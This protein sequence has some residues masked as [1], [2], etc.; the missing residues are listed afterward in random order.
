M[1]KKIIRALFVIAAI[2]TIYEYIMICGMF[3]APLTFLIMSVIGIINVILSLIEKQYS[4]ALLYLLAT[5]GL[6]MGY[7]KVLF[8][9]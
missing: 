5:I 1:Y 7:A 9:L 8:Y 2:L 4:L 6:T 3:T